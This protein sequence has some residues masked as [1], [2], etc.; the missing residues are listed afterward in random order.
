MMPCSYRYYVRPH[1]VGSAP[2]RPLLVKREEAAAPPPAPESQKPRVI[3]TAAPY[4]A[5]VCQYAW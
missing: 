3:D 1:R 4:V 5:L 2:V